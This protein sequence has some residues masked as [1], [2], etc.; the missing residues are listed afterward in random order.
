MKKYL[1]SIFAVLMFCTINVS[2]QTDDEFDLIQRAQMIA[3][4]KK[5]RTENTAK[6]TIIAEQKSTIEVYKKLDGVQESRILDLK[7]ALKFRTEAGNI[8]VKIE[9]MYKDQI[10]D[11]KAEVNRLR[12]E[13]DKLRKSRDRRS[14]IM[15]IVG[16][17]AG[18]LIF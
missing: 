16:A 8:D 10:F 9:T 4:I 6:D 14:L 7:E 5:L 15:G 1:L 18:A 12:T 2:A 3:E 11:Y 13:N 17:A